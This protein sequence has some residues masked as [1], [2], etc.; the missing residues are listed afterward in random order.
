MNVD[1]GLILISNLINLPTIQQLSIRLHLIHA[2]CTFN[3][4]FRLLKPGMIIYAYLHKF[5]KFRT[6]YSVLAH[7]KVC[8]GIRK[9][10]TVYVQM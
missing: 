7:Q 5:V 9:Y 8:V 4:P 2:N 10:H 1:N 3:E 6:T